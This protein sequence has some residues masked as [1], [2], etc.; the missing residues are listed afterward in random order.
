MTYRITAKF[1]ENILKRKHHFLNVS[2]TYK[3][4]HIGS[5]DF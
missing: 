1:V 4:V 3:V 5:K 2:L